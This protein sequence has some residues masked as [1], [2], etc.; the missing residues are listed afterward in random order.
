AVRAI[1]PDVVVLAYGV[2]ESQPWLLPVGWVAHLRTD[3]LTTRRLGSQYRRRVAPRL[4]RVV[5]AYRRR[6]AGW[7]GTRTWQTRPARFGAAMRQLIRLAR[8]D[9]ASLVL[10]VDVLPPGGPLRHWLPGM[11]ERHAVVSGVLRDVVASFASPEV[12]LIDTANL[13]EELGG[14]PAV[15][16]GLHLTAAGHERLGRRLAAE[17]LAWLEHAPIPRSSDQGG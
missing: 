16:D 14:D 4:W 9:C 5:R 10:V 7:V 3:H 12:R 8:T 15:P 13:V 17:V 6:A 1:S 11:P 2:N